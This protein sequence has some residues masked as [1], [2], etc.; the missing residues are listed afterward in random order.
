MGCCS[1]GDSACNSCSSADGCSTDDKQKHTDEMIK[2]RL[3]SIKYKI[4]VMS[5]KGGVGKSTVSVSLASMINAMG[6]SVGILDADIH[7]PNIPKMLGITKKGATNNE[8][9]IVPF[10]PMEGL[11]VM[12]VGM[13]VENDDEAII[14]R[15]PVK[16]SII[17]QFVSDVA[18]GDLDFLIID[19]PPG[20]GDEQLSVAHIIGKVDGSVIV[21]TPQDVALLDSRK[22]VTFSRKLGV[23]ILGIIENMSGFSCP[24]CGSSVDI[25]KTGGGERAARELN[26]NF[27]GKIPLEEQVVHDGDAGTPHVLGHPGSHVAKA[28]KEIAI[29]ILKL[30][31]KKEG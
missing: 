6:Y 24:H 7:G 15:A 3:S 19:L 5:G 2:R 9:G 30:T 20:T 29:N 13:L 18:W 27:L 16:H 21:T 25:F 4:M 12:S 31:I 14:W 11:K 23:P 26:V 8:D 22:S 17:Q 1:S 10:E 28:M